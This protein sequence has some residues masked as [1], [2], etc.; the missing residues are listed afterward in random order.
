MNCGAKIDISDENNES[1]I[2]EESNSRRGQDTEQDQVPS[3]QFTIAG[4]KLVFPNSIQ[5]YTRRRKDLANQIEPFIRNQKVQCEKEIEDLNFDNIDKCVDVFADFGRSVS[6]KLIAT[7]HQKLMQEKIY[8]VSIENISTLYYNA[9]HR[10]SAEYDS[11]F[12]QYLKIINDSEQLKQYR[13]LKRSGRSYWQGG[14][15]GIRG[16]L[17]GAAKAGALNVGTGII[18][19]IGDALTDAGD[20]NKTYKEKKSLLQ[21]KKWAW[22]FEISLLED[23]YQMYTVYADILANEGKLSLPNLDESLSTTYFKNGKNCTSQA[24]QIDLFT[25]ALQC[26]PYGGGI[27]VALGKIIGYTNAELLGMYDYFLASHQVYGYVKQVVSLQYFSA[28]KAITGNSYADLDK[29]IALIDQQLS[30]FTDMKC[31]SQPF[32][33]ACIPY[34]KALQDTRQGLMAKRLTADD[35]NHFQSIKDLD[36]Y[37]KERELYKTC[38]QRTRTQIVSLK[39][40]DRLLA[41][42]EAQ[43]FHSPVILQDINKWKEQLFS[44]HKQEDIYIKSFEWYFAKSW[45]DWESE[46]VISEFPEE[47]HAMLADIQ[48]IPITKFIVF[49][50]LKI[51]PRMLSFSSI[52]AWIII[53]DY[54]LFVI[55]PN[56][57]ERHIIRTCEL[58]HIQ[59]RQDELLLYKTDSTCE[60]VTFL[61][62]SNG[63][64]GLMS[65]LSAVNEELSRARK[66]KANNCC[67]NCGH[68]LFDGALFCGNCG[69]KLQ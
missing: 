44:C 22:I 23:M 39:D 4:T 66:L 28:V 11:F 45:T 17:V 1:H 16:A 9:A 33:E 58:D 15:F 38:R 14:G 32:A 62:T 64:S 52:D 48:Y 54:Y 30:A 5:E 25:R 26:Y 59:F 47:V 6:D 31:V 8:T 57:S 36:L 19:G 60:D 3:I 63:D 27:Y 46:T 51:Y 49:Y 56:K 50:T 12:E 2:A 7:I 53:S 37:L 24:E 13:E 34:E 55:I 20:Q 65:T 67:P 41:Q 69:L 10:F 68:S 29:K 35:G 42:A 61:L 18:R 43:H 21:S 40:Q